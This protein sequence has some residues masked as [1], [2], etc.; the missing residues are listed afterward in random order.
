MHGLELVFLPD[1]LQRARKVAASDPTMREIYEVLTASGPAPSDDDQA[2]KLL[3]RKSRKAAWDAYLHAAEACGLL[4]N[5]ML[6]NLR[7]FAPD[8]FRSAMA[9]AMTCWVLAGGMKHRVTARPPGKGSKVLDMRVHHGGQAHAEVEVKAPFVAHPRSRRRTDSVK[10]IADKLREANSQ[11]QRGPCNIV[12]VVPE[13]PVPV[14]RSRNQA[15]A[16]LIGRH[17]Y[18]VPVA[19]SSDVE[20]PPEHVEFQ[21]TG[22]F[23]RPDETRGTPRFTRVSA[24][25]TIEEVPHQRTNMLYDT[26]VPI[27]IKHRVLV[28][29]NPH[30]IAPLPETVF[31]N[32]P[33]FV[34]RDGMMVWTDS[35]PGSGAG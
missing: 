35:T 11:F 23:L 5:D 28:V 18:V 8:Q 13:L 16:A 6:G 17:V 3:V 34:V 19:L 9:E 14:Y 7:S 33:Q 26:T 20:P 29:H 4:D 2:W 25:I 32:C 1:V 10:P 12:A 24:L 30:A 15:V 22:L 21:P 31:A 27:E